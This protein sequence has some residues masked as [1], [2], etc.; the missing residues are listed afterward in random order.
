MVYLLIGQDIQ[1]K[2]IQ[3][4]KIKQE[5]L[6]KELQDFNSDTLYAKDTALK[7]IQERLASLP[8]KN[9]KRVVVIK[10]A[11]SLDD[12]SRD[13]LGAYCKKAPKELIL[14]LDFEHYDHKN[15][16]IKDLQGCATITRFRETVN[17]DAF[18]LAR[19]I[20]SGKADA[21]LRLLNQLLNNGEAPERILGALRFAWERQNM[22]SKDSRRRLKLLLACDIE[23]KTGRLKPAYALEKLIVSLCCFAQSPR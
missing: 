10:D 6:P 11:Q 23:I 18:S 8:L 7:E 15:R 14:V 9:A 19:Q 4:Q 5:F 16:F 12:A 17:P 13:F 2:E 21:A 1:A 3:L 20:E 22:G